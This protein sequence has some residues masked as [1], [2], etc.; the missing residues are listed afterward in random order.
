MEETRLYRELTSSIKSVKWACRRDCARH[1]ADHLKLIEPRAEQPAFRSCRPFSAASLD[2][3]RSWSVGKQR[4]AEWTRAKAM[5]DIMR[6]CHYIDDSEP[7]WS[8]KTIM[9]WCRRHGYSDF[10]AW[11][12]KSSVDEDVKEL[13]STMTEARATGTQSNVTDDAAIDVESLDPSTR[14][15]SGASGSSP[16][17]GKVMLSI[18]DVADVELTA[19]TTEAIEKLGF[20]LGAQVLDDHVISLSRI[21]FSHLWKKVGEDLIRRSLSESWRRSKGAKPET[22]SLSDVFEAV[23]RRPEFDL[24]TDDGLGVESQQV[25]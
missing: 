3:Y 13:P 15:V 16:P 7:H 23:Q 11:L 20:K 22:I 10:E 8:T 17:S 5:A 14:K 24:L 9:I 4:C 19:Y 1:L 25:L 21:L 6:Q 2:T 18:D 12:L